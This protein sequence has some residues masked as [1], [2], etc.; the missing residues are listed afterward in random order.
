MTA[1]TDTLVLPAPFDTAEVGAYTQ[2][3]RRCVAFTLKQ[4]GTL[5][6]NQYAIAWITVVEDRPWS[7]EP[8]RIQTDR[9]PGSMDAM[10]QPFTEAGRKALEG[11]LL[12]HIARYGFGRWWTEL[13]ADAG[14]DAR[15]DAEKR[16][17]DLKAVSRFLTDLVEL[18]DMYANGVLDI[19][20]Y[21]PRSVDCPQPRADRIGYDGRWERVTVAAELSF[22]GE[23]VGWL[24]DDAKLVPVGPYRD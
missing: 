4:P 9:R 14:I 20:P 16:L 19:A 7:G 24:T 2:Y 17:A 5:F 8:L 15:N 21:P 1:T 18:G 11:L 6:R 3:G 12:P 23:L 22:G 10:R 13:H